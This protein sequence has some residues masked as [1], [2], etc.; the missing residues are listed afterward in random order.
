MTTTVTTSNFCS[1]SKRSALSA[2]RRSASRFAARFSARISAACEG[3]VHDSIHSENTELVVRLTREQTHSQKDEN[4]AHFAC[5][6]RQAFSVLPQVPPGKKKNPR[7]HTHTY[8]YIALLLRRQPKSTCMRC[9]E[10]QRASIYKMAVS[11]FSCAARRAET[12]A[13]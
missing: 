11:T 1:S 13:V 4:H 2:S 10:G 6:K 7:V 9:Q 5:D 12:L 8:M 3:S